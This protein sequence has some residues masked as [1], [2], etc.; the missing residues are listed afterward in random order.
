[1]TTSSARL[2]SSRPGVV[3][4]KAPLE[5]LRCPFV[6]GAV[7][8]LVDPQAQIAADGGDLV[9]PDAI[10][11]GRQL[12]VFARRDLGERLVENGQ[13]LVAI[14]RADRQRAEPLHATVEVGLHGV[15]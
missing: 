14:R 6:G 5:P 13:R 11:R 2:S 9:V 8:D 3:Q 12:F 4:P 1:M 15:E 10:D 7:G